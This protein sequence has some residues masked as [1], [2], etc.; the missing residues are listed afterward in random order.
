MNIC[1]HQCKVYQLE[2]CATLRELKK[3]IQTRMEPK[4]GL[5]YIEDCF[6]DVGLTL[7][8]FPCA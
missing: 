4:Q 7:H 2:E 1:K 5:G 6:K 3:L 8:G